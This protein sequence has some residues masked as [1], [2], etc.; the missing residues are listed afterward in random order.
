M[1]EEGSVPDI[2]TNEVEIDYTYKS[3][4]KI[5]MT[6]KE[7]CLIAKQVLSVD[8]ELQPL[9]LKKTIESKDYFLVV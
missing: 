8:E 1:I 2:D 3:V 7:S 9:K 4:L 5:P 6:D